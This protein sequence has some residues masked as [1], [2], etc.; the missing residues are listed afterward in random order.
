LPPLEGGTQGLRGHGIT[1]VWYVLNPLL[2]LF[3]YSAVIP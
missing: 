2:W 3:F 1:P